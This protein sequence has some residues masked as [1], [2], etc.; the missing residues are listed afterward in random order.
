LS[1]ANRQV[2]PK[3]FLYWIRE[4]LAFAQSQVAPP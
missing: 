1:G 4:I 2:W 3:L